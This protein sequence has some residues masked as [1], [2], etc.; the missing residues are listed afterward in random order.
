MKLHSKSH[1]DPEDVDC[2]IYNG[3]IATE[4]LILD[5]ALMAHSHNILAVDR[6]MRDMTKNNTFFCY[7]I[8]ILCGD[9]RQTL[10]VIP[11][12]SRSHIANASMMKC[13][14]I[15]NKSIR[16]NL[17]V[18]MRIIRNGNNPD[19]ITFTNFLLDVGEN[20]INLERIINTNTIRIPDNLLIPSHMPNTPD[21]QCFLTYSPEK[22]K[23]IARF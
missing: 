22:L 3:A 21:T 19:A 4:L 17:T 7:K 8:I 12:D 23:M 9:P 15:W 1:F 14:H 13:P 16:I 5:E 2:A 11:K 18:N 10:P 20:N 6:M